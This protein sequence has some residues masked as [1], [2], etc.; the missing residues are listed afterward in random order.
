MV[1]MEAAPSQ[2]GLTVASIRFVGSSGLF[3]G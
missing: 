2:W 1:R 3:S